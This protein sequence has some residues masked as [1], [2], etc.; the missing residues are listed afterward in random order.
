VL[1]SDINVFPQPSDQGEDMKKKCLSWLAALACATAVASADSIQFRESYQDRL[2]GFS[3]PD[4]G[5][6]YVEASF[7][8]FTGSG[9]ITLPGLAGIGLDEIDGGGISIGDASLDFVLGDES[10][11]ASINRLVLSD[12]T[13]GRLVFTRS[14][15]VLTFSFSAPSL[16][17]PSIVTANYAEP[18]EDRTPKRFS[19]QTEFHLRLGSLEFARRIYF[20]G[21]ASYQTRLVGS[22]DEA[23]EFVLATVSATGAADYLKPRVTLTSPRSNQRVSNEVVT[24]TGR[25]TDNGELTGVFLRVND[26]DEPLNAG[27][28][29]E[30]GVWS[31]DASLPPGTNTFRAWGVDLDNHVSLTN[32]VKCF[33]VVT[34]ALA[35]SVSEGGRVTGVSNMQVLEIGRGYRA[36]AIPGPTN[37][38][39]WWS[40]SVSGVVSTNPVLPFLMAEGL[41]LRAQFI[42]N[43]WHPNA[44]VFNGLFVHESEPTP[45]NS[46][47]VT[48]TLASRGRV[49]GRVVQ[50]VR[51]RGFAGQLDLEGR[52]VISVPGAPAL[53]LLLD[54]DLQ[55]GSGQVDGTVSNAVFQS[56][57]H[58][59]RQVGD[60]VLVGRHNF[61]IPGAT[62][63]ES[64]SRPAGDGVGTLTITANGAATF[65]G[66]L[67]EGTPLVAA[68]GI[69]KLG[70][71]PIH[72][73][74]FGGQGFFIGAVNVSTGSPPFTVLGTNLI[75]F[76][77]P[78]LLRQQTYPGGFRHADKLLLGTRYTPPPRGSN[79]LNWT[80]GLIQL[81]GGGLDATLQNPLAHS[82]VSLT[83][84]GNTNSLLLT[85]TPSTG[86]IAGSFLH[87]LTG[88]IT[89]LNGCVLQQ[90]DGDTGRGWFI[91]TNQSGFL[92]LL[93]A[94]SLAQ[95]G[96]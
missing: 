58:A 66:N 46:G 2:L 54:F 44:G 72:A 51:S 70:Y 40:N 21:T 12:A 94:G 15:N 65:A 61:V 43:P 31:V 11:T 88:R 32:V 96:F 8:N 86:R 73:V 95:F 33:R 93:P 63:E 59:E 7:V 89:R 56:P 53:S 16:S 18:G 71:L 57:L 68:G 69:S 37:L 35:L 25:A 75:W 23:E 30:T 26:A 62:A 55:S 36:T 90:P 91:S 27:Y 77:P 20:Q 64:E 1:K 48:L 49:T 92:N 85:L 74:Q 45:T 60:P 22:G 34:N 80:T 29:P 83:A 38:F 9:V 6:V 17:V 81:D 78:G 5:T 41:E 24:V 52:A 28:N 10:V 82:G 19:G 42:P 47:F 87:R 14:G 84:S 39:A 13:V 3:D 76:K 67:G 4:L 79:A 50:G